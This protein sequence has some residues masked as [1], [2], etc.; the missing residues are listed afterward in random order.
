MLN[1]SAPHIKTF[2]SASGPKSHTFLEQS[3]KKQLYIQRIYH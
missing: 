3:E 1:K 2:F